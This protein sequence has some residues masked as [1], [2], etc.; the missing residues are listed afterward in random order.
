MIAAGRKATVAQVALAW[1]LHRPAVSVPIASATTVE[2]LR[3][4][5]LAAQLRLEPSDMEAL[6][7]ASSDLPV[8]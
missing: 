1:L 4:L 2:Q 6:D 8:A 5:L 7:H 3:E